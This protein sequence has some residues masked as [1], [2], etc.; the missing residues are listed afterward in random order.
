MGKLTLRP[1]KRLTVR[2]IP[3]NRTP[4]LFVISFLRAGL[5]AA[6]CLGSFFPAQAQ[7][8]NYSLV[9]AFQQGNAKGLS[10]YAG[11]REGSDGALYGTAS[12]GGRQNQGTLF[13][14]NKDGSGF[15][16]LHHFGGFVGDG[17]RPSWSLIEA[18]DGRLYGVTTSGGGTTNVG[19]V[20]RIQKDGTGYEVLHSFTGTAE[21]GASPVSGLLE[22]S[23]G[24]LYGMG[25]IVGAGLVATVF[26]LNKD[27]S[28]FAVTRRLWG[29]DE[30][31]SLHGPLVE[32]TNGMLYGTSGSGGDF[33]EGTVFRLHKD[34][35][36]F[37]IIRHFSAYF[38]DGQYPG[39]GLMRASND[40]FYGTASWGGALGDG[41]IVFVVN[42]DGS[43]SGKVLN[44]T[45]LR[46]TSAEGKNP[47]TVPIEGRDGFLYGT[48]DRGGTNDSGVVYKVRKDGTGY[49]VL[50]RFNWRTTDGL[51]ARGDLIQ[52]SDG[53]LYGTTREGGSLN[54]GT[55]YKLEPDGSAYQVLV[56]FDAEGAEAWAPLG[57]LVEASDERLYGAADSGGQ[58]DKGAVFGLNRDGSGYTELHSFAGE[59]ADGA[60]PRVTL[61]AASDGRLYGTTAN[62]GVNNAGVLFGLDRDAGN[63]AVLHHFRYHATNG[64][65][66]YASLLEGSDGRLYGTTPSGGSNNYGVAFSIQKD[67]H[68]FTVLRSFS[69]ASNNVRTPTAPLIEGSD[70]VLYGCGVKGDNPQTSA[71]FKLNK[72]GSG[73]A[74]LRLIPGAGQQGDDLGQRGRVVEGSDGWLYG[75]ASAAGSTNAGIVFKMTKEG[76]GFE[77]LHDFA[78]APGDGANPRGSLVEGRDSA[79]YGTTQSGGASNAGTLYKLNKDGTGFV[80][81]RSYPVIG[82]DGFKPEVPLVKS[83]D[84]AFYG[85]TPG[86]LSSQPYASSGLVFRFGHALAVSSTNNAAMLVVTGVPGYPY[87]LQRSPDLTTWT[88]LETLVMP[89][90][91]S[92]QFADT[93]APTTAAFY[94]VHVP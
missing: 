12:E 53:A 44:F 93:N 30:P 54:K 61:I 34:G 69:T 23:D 70:G 19:T 13:R 67:G 88:T 36:G 56:N 60:S 9:R 14:L 59:P 57:A 72:D 3:T 17:R 11:L 64:A 81:L 32:G 35:S 29:P 87:E 86:S 1:V 75:T 65:W 55:I 39:A 66:P 4:Q 40:L 16:V 91:A 52:A 76:D 2:P 6:F 46:G 84:G 15:T 78:G 41:G 20:F 50:H 85:V 26:K 22:A 82:A 47:F 27:G 24:A 68:G 58:M 7:L 28:D 38:S 71:I 49:T 43:S 31:H 90:S 77:V 10:P 33:G 25:G 48:T 42:H 94:R 45:G 62:G 92:F 74:V 51:R 8:T 73:F 37:E 89:A 80:L 63:Y 79:L 5:L 18:G 83:S 21:D